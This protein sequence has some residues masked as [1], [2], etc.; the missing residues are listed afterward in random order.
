MIK[1]LTNLSK[2]KEWLSVKRLICNDLQKSKLV[3]VLLLC[4]VAN[5]VPD[6]L[7]AQDSSETDSAFT[8]TTANTNKI[9]SLIV[10]EVNADSL[11][12]ISLKNDLSTEQRRNKLLPD[13]LKSASDS[14]INNYLIS[15]G[16]DSL[17]I[18]T[19]TQVQIPDSLKNIIAPTPYSY[20]KRK[21]I[22]LPS[23]VNLSL[24]E[25]ADI[26]AEHYLAVEQYF[27]NDFNKL[28]DKTLLSVT[29]NNIELNSKAI[30]RARPLLQAERLER[31]EQNMTSSYEATLLKTEYERTFKERVEIVLRLRSFFMQIVQFD[32]DYMEVYVNSSGIQLEPLNISRSP[33]INH[34]TEGIPWYERTVTIAFPRRKDGVDAWRDRTLSLFVRLRDPRLLDSKDVQT[35][36]KFD[37]VK[38]KNET[39]AQN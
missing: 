34:I 15:I 28:K 12:N 2:S 19:E 35:L 11:G 25:T 24:T 5:T 22:P 32:L 33:V 18:A 3:F 6:S 20:K 29:I 13:S 27:T 10:P 37:L 4:I 31:I 7:S 17:T 38:K 39:E 9:D 1:V 30:L 14:L 26:K 16:A 8:N 36:F 23:H 21:F